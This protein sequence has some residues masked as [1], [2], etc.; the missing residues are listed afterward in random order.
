MG[1]AASNPKKK[2][3]KKGK[4]GKADAADKAEKKKKSYGREGSPDAMRK[5]ISDIYKGYKE[6]KKK[7]DPFL[8]EKIGVTAILNDEREKL[9]GLLAKQTELSNLR[10]P[11][12]EY[13][14]EKDADD[15]HRAFSKF[16]ADKALLIGILATRTKWQIGAISEVFE[17]KYG[18]PLLEQVINDMTTLLG[19][20]ITGKETG[21][22]KLLTYRILPNHERDAAFLRDFSDGYGLDDENLI[23][24]VCTRSNAGEWVRVRLCVCCEDG[25]GTVFACV[26]VVRMVRGSVFACVCVV[27]MCTG[28]Y[29]CRGLI[30]IAAVR[31]MLLLSYEKAT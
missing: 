21:L 22:G 8:A 25:E 15:I 20:L 18:T 1:C 3:G 26:C 28:G 31:A 24:I 12:M 27:R 13:T 29:G 16:S 19:K 2:N 17:K 10:E 9:L 30:S 5:E 4:K 14:W 23:E 6:E 11:L 7:I